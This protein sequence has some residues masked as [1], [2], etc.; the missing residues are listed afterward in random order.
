[1][2]QAPGRIVISDKRL[3]CVSNLCQQ[4]VAVPPW[5]QYIH[6]KEHQEYRSLNQTWCQLEPSDKRWIEKSSSMWYAI[7]RVTKN[8]FDF[9]LSPIQSRRMKEN[10][11]WKRKTRK[12]K[13][14]T[15]NAREVRVIFSKIVSR[16]DEARK[17]ACLA[18]VSDS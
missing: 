2:W 4:C 7:W 9:S 16:A 14:S 1:M 3:V 11:Y 6:I 5:H 15:K 10:I 12:R 13:D 18:M 17:K 8:D